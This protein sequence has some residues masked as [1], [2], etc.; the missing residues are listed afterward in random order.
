MVLLDEHKVLYGFHIPNNDK[1]IVSKVL[2]SPGL[3]TTGMINPKR[4]NAHNYVYWYD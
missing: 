1:N 4:Q 2:I 3:V